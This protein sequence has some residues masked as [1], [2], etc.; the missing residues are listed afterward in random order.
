MKKLLVSSMVTLVAVLVLSCIVIAQNQPAAPAAQQ[1][2]RPETKPWNLPE[3]PRTGAAPAAPAPRPALFFREEWKMPAGEPRASNPDPCCWPLTS[4]S[5]ASSN[6]EL[7]V[8]GSG[9]DLNLVGNPGDDF[10]PIHSW[11]GLCPTACALTFKDKNNY[12]DLSKGKIR[13]NTK[14]VGFH[15]VHPLIK[16]ADGTYLLGDFP[17]GATGDWKTSEFYP[18]EIRWLRADT[19]RVTGYGNWITKPDLT[20]VD[21]VGYADLMPGSGHNGAAGI[22]VALMEV[23]GKSVS[24]SGSVQSQLNK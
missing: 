24:R 12:V 19:D 13:W 2:A 22:D 5:V 16:L 6:L 18:S 8:Y 9:K 14:V 11:T 10:N 17:D 23:Y 1:Q 7:N 21:E 20:K 4:E 15:V 3:Q